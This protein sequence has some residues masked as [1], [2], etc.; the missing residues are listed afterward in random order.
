MIMQMITIQLEISSE[1][2]KYSNVFIY[3]EWNY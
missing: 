1:T 2:T 3:V